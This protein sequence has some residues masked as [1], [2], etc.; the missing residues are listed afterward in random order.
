MFRKLRYMAMGALIAYFFD[1]QSG[2]QRR[3]AIRDRVASRA[4][5]KAESMGQP[6]STE[7]RP[8]DATLARNVET[9]IFR[10]AGIPTGRIDVDAENGKG[11]LRGAGEAPELTQER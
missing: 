11:V 2:G 9:E 10:D 6:V 4:R 1:P 5:M 8:D 7:A 3:A